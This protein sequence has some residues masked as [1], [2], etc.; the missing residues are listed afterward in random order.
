MSTVVEALYACIGH[1]YSMA[2][3]REIA[4]ASAMKSRL[5]LSTFLARQRRLPRASNTVAM[6]RQ[7]V[8]IEIVSTGQ[9]Y[10]TEDQG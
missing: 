4:R 10:G 8:I 2:V 6:L 9:R 5:T 7:P 3:S 1:P